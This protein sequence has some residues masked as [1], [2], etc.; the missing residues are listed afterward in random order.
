MP[1]V[2]NAEQFFDASPAVAKF[3]LQDNG[4]LR[5][6]DGVE[7]ATRG[8]LPGTPWSNDDIGRHGVDH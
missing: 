3:V 1:I 2:T 5:L 8:S 6:L 7:W 4:R